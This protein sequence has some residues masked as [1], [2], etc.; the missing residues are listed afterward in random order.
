MALNAFPCTPTAPAWSSE[1]P[2][3][4]R[5]DVAEPFH[6]W[7]LRAT[8]WDVMERVNGVQELRG[9]VHFEPQGEGDALA[10]IFCVDAGTMISQIPV[11]FVC[12][13]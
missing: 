13:D 10:G 6:H 5:S 2:V 4:M 12:A 1:I 3:V 9:T 11:R 8:R 7:A